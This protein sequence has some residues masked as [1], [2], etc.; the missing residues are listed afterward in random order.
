MEKNL[1][2]KSNTLC[3]AAYK[4]TLNEKRLITTAIS[5]IDGRKKIELDHKIKINLP[6]FQKLW[7]LRN[8]NTWRD[9]RDSLKTLYERSL[10]AYVKE[11]DNTVSIIKMR[12]IY[13]AKFNEENQEI[14]I[15]FSPDILKHISQISG[16]FTSYKLSD[17][18]SFKSTYTFALYDYLLSWKKV[19][20]ATIPINELREVFGIEVQKY[21]KF[22]EL[23]RSCIDV[24]VKEINAKSPFQVLNVS[25]HRVKRKVDSIEF[26]F[27]EKVKITEQEWDV[28]HQSIIDKKNKKRS[29]AIDKK[30]AEM[31]ASLTNNTQH[32]N[33]SSL[34]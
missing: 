19:M 7:S 15:G 33:V 10:K 31:N 28:Y 12:W 9:L 18:L 26:Q 30:L 4:L 27:K 25:Y 13:L 23:K 16:V 17:I 11:E 34:N 2:T 22:K 6:E 8:S 29:K 20:R 1:V 21:P 24:A 14:E 32:V 3:R 5:K